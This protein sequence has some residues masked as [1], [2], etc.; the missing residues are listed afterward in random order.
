M[1][2]YNYT[3]ELYHY[4]RKGMKW[5][6]HI[7]GEERKAANELR[8]KKLQ[9]QNDKI[10]SDFRKS[11]GREDSYEKTMAYVG[12]KMGQLNL[13]RNDRAK[14]VQDINDPNKNRAVSVGKA[15]IKTNLKDYAISAIPATAVAVG[16]AALTANPFL[17]IAA[18]QS[19]AN[20]SYLGIAGTRVYNTVHNK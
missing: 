9:A 19:V 5:G 4:G 18:G 13:R 6:E 8:R 11:K 7:Y 1:W 10:S 12:N 15:Y 14:M 17:A 3:D 16:T 20:L 2:Q